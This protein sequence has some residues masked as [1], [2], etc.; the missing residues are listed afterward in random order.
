MPAAGQGH[1]FAYRQLLG[2]SASRDSDRLSGFRGV[3]RRL[4]RSVL[5]GHSQ[6]RHSA[7]AVALGESDRNASGRGDRNCECT[8]E[9]SLSVRSP[10]NPALAA[11]ARLC[12]R[13]WSSRRLVGTEALRQPGSRRAEIALLL[14]PAPPA[15][16]PQPRRCARRPEVIRRTRPRRPRGRDRRQTGNGHPLTSPSRARAQAQTPPED[17]ERAQVPTAAVWNRARRAWRD[18]CRAETERSPSGPRTGH[19]PASRHPTV[20]QRGHRGPAQ[21]RHSRPSLQTRRCP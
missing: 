7:L 1:A 17:L 8:S 6:R 5:T 15:P 11:W 3:E 10:R 16:L 2:K 20:R 9:R 12:K 14:P 18:R 13:L 21:A 4:D 19:I